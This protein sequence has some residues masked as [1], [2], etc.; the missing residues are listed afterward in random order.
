M[1]KHQLKI[2]AIAVVLGAGLLA[3]CGKK[4]S[5]APHSSDSTGSAPTAAAPSAATMTPSAPA[6][7]MP[8]SGTQTPDAPASTPAP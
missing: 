2:A 6:A 4:E 7:T 3:G 1:N 8:E 5:S